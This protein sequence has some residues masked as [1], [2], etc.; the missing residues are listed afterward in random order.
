LS[1]S[2]L[3]DEAYMLVTLE[4]L[5]QEE[6]SKYN[7]TVWASDMGSP[8]LSA[9]KTLLVWLLDINDNVYTFSQTITP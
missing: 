7:M 1:V 8:T 9:L 6:V 3:T 5:N 4:G 2:L